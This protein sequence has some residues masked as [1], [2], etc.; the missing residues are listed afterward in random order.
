MIRGFS[1]NGLMLLLGCVCLD[2]SVAEAQMFGQRSVGGTLR[3]QA[4]PGQKAAAATEAATGQIEGS[5]RFLREN[6]ARGSFVGSD[7]KEQAG[8]VGSQQAL[9][10]GRVQAAT[11]SLK[12][13]ADPTARINPPLPPLGP[14]AMY[15]PRLVIEPNSLVLRSMETRGPS[16][17]SAAQAQIDLEEG[18][19]ALAPPDKYRVT[20][21][22][23]LERLTGGKVQ[24]QRQG[25]VAIL[26]GE[27]DSLDEFEKIKILLSFEPGIYR[28]DNRVTLR[29]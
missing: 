24:L 11:E 5:E 29:E 16:G 23:R 17:R 26:I 9:G 12:A 3:R 13:E 10:S 14:K 7:R 19:I 6:R 18:V 2:A 22:Q 15:H 21:E 28:F 8:F 1:W 25:D 27:V 20:A 4:S